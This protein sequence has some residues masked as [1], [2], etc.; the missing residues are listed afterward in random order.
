[1]AA[2]GWSVS[3]LTESIKLICKVCKALRDTGGASSDYQQTVAFLQGLAT[4]LDSVRTFNDIFASP[5][6]AVFIRAQVDLVREPVEE[7]TR[8]IEAMFKQRLGT[9]AMKGMRGVVFGGHRKAQWALRFAKKAKNL[10]ERIAAPLNA[11][12][13]ALS[14]QML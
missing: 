12:Q 11:I 10:S 2:L 13:I 4:T 14:V 5:E 9:Q 7:F 8:R 1:M 3:D 6:D